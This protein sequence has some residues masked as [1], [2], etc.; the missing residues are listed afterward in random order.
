MLRKILKDFLSKLK[1]SFLSV[2][3]IFLLVIFLHLTG[4][5]KLNNQT[6]I[7]FIISAGILVFGMT[8]FSIGTDA[9]MMPMGGQIANKLI[10]KSKVYLL[11]GVCLILGIT[12]TI[13]EPDLSVLATLVQG[14]IPYRTTIITISIGVGIFLAFAVIRVFFKIKLKY[15]IL[16]LYGLVFILASICDLSFIPVAF[17]SGGVTTGPVTVPFIMALGVG[18]ASITNFNEAKGNENNFGMVAL[19]SVGPIMAM[20][21]L[22]IINGSASVTAQSVETAS[23]W[24]LLV[25]YLGSVALA[26]I[27]IVIVFLILQFTYLRLSK[28][29]VYSILFGV[30]NSYVGLVLFLSAAEFGFLRVGNELGI[31]LGQSALASTGGK[32]VLVII[33]FA[34]GFLAVLAEPAVHVLNKL[35]AETSGGVISKLAMMLSLAIGVGVAVGLCMLRIIFDIDFLVIAGIGYGIALILAVIVDDIYVGIAFDSGGVASGP[36]SSSFILPLALGVCSAMGKDVLTSGF[37][38][39]AMIALTPLITIQVLGVIVKITN[40][41]VV[42][43]FTE[44]TKIITFKEGR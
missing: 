3:P 13:A 44:D 15:L 22:G 9:S 12:I 31:I 8:A 42:P 28:T 17:D 29:K 20:L 6:L 10:G 18:I 27:P 43:N 32:Y 14:A 16:L 37:G 25:K 11:I 19:C 23:Y 35:I 36:M 40:H 33:G 24:T 34:L 26:L 4:I 7:Y 2:L 38:I 41:Q 1:E 30:I 21:L 5:A 39:V